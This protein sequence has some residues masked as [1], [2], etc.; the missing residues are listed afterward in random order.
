MSAFIALLHLHYV[1]I[2]YVN[3]Q[4]TISTLAANVIKVITTLNHPLIL[5][6]HSI[7]PSK[8]YEFHVGFCVRADSLS[9]VIYDSFLLTYRPIGLH[10]L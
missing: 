1:Y 2:Q 5:C 3:L 10:L 9:H 6:T 7:C 8:C 4:L